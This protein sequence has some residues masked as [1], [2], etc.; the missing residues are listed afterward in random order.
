[1]VFQLLN[2]KSKKYKPTNIVESVCSVICIEQD[3]NII[4]ILSYSTILYKGIYASVYLRLCTLCM[5]ECNE[6]Q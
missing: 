3:G 4:V 6:A 5:C 2:T 1:M